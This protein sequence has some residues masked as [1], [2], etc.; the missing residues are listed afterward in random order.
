MSTS[1][2]IWA[3]AAGA[4]TLIEL[5]VVIAII[6]ILAAMLL[7]ALANAKEKAKRTQCVNNLKQLTLGML[8]YAYDNRDKFPDGRGVFWSWDLP[9]S[10]ADAMLS[11]NNQFQ[12]SCYCPGTSVRFSAQDNLNLWNY[13]YRVIGY[14]LTLPGTPGLCPTNQNRTIIPEAIKYGPN[15]VAPLPV[16]DKVL[17]CDATICRPSENNELQKFTGNYNYMDVIGSYPLHHL[18]PHVKNGVPIGGNLG[19]LDGHVE[20]R[21]F[22]KMQVR[23]SGA[24]WSSTSGGDPSCPTYWW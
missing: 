23:A 12:K 19:M 13:P 21:K 7:P 18:S 9:R 24:V 15:L 22:Q 14:T 6:A 11:A 16:S 3:K 1:K 17:T 5:L 4:F 10:A 8:G 20:W 2:R